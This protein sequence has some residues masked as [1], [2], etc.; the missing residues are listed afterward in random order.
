MGH[1]TDMAGARGVW[2]VAAMA[3]KYGP[4]FKL[5]L[6]GSVLVVLSDPQTISRVARKTGPGPYMSKPNEVYKPLEKALT[7]S[8]PSI[9]TA[10]DGPYWKAVRQAAAPCFSISNLKNVMP[11]VLQLTKRVADRM[12][13]AAAAAAT[14]ANNS[15]SAVGGLFDV[16]D[17]AKRITSDVMGHMLLGEDLQG[18]LWRPSE[19]LDL[20]Y[21]VLRAQGELINNPLHLWQVWRPDVRLQKR[22]LAKHNAIMDGKMDRLMAHP[23]PDYTIAAHLLQARVNGQP[24]NRNQLKTEVAAFMAAGFETTSHAITWSLAL[25]AAHPKVQ[26]Q[27]LEELAAQGLAAGADSMQLRDIEQADFAALPL[28]AAVIKESLRL[29]PPAPWGGTKQAPCDVTLCGHTVKKVRL[30]QSRRCG[31]DVT[32]CGHTVKKGTL[33]MMPLLAVSLSTANYGSDAMLFKPQ[34]W[35]AG[36]KPAGTAAEGAAD[37][38]DGAADRD[39]QPRSAAGVGSKGGSSSSSSSSSTVPDPQTFMT[40]PRDCIGQALAKLELMAVLATLLGRFEFAPGPKLAQELAAAAA[41]GQPPA[42]AL[43]GLAGVHVTM[44]PEDGTMLLRVAPRR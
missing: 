15:S 1:V 3:E 7:P 29:C 10:A 30:T 6:M 41:T 17:A 25:L 40:G 42:A 23:P 32:L 21:P 31:C 24:L 16:S 20:F 12:Q 36:S 27:V 9:L 28:L 39:Q 13:A 43:H 33:V 14:D 22:C 37:D 44:Q 4:L 35:L 19:Y 18:T 38:D 34:R 5:Q 26:Q 2:N 11:L 8:L